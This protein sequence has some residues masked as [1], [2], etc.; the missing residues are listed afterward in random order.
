M[1]FT[2]VSYI[3]AWLNCQG[4]KAHTP[5]N[6]PQI[7]NSA[8]SAYSAGENS[9]P[10]S[11]PGAFATLRSITCAQGRA[12]SGPVWAGLGMGCRGAKPAKN[13][14]TPVYAGLNIRATETGPAGS[15]GLALL[16]FPSEPVRKPKGGI[17]P[18]LPGFAR[19]CPPFYGGRCF[20]RK[21]E[22]THPEFQ[23]SAENA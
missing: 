8:C 2:E 6:N 13:R 5:M 9:P 16:G 4:A 7:Q 15:A 11:R 22:S 21:A 1:C 14:F 18:P 12:W 10:P 23:K 17:R 3:V 20:R 19:L